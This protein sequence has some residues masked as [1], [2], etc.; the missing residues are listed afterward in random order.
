MAAIPGSP[1]GPIKPHLEDM[2]IEELNLT[3][4]KFISEIKKNDGKEDYPGNTL[5]EMVMAIQCHLHV[6]GKKD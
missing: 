3:L 1:Y 5:Y 6:C 4:C 2:T